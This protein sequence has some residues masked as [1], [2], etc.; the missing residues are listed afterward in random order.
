MAKRVANRADRVIRT[1]LREAVHFQT[2]TE[3][4]TIRLSSVLEYTGRS[5]FAPWHRIL[6]GTHDFTNPAGIFTPLVFV[7]VETA[8][9]ACDPNFRVEV[10][11]E[12]WLGHSRDSS[13]AV[14]NIVREGRHTVV[15]PGGAVLARARLLNVFTRYDPDPAR[16]RVTELP[17]E[18]GLGA[19]PGR[20]I[21]LP[22]IESLIDPARKPDFADAGAHVWHYGQTDPNRHINGTAYL[23][24]MEEFAADSLYAAGHDLRRLYAARARIIYRKPSFRGE[25]YRRVAWFRSEAPLVLAGAFY[26][27]KQPVDAQ[28][29]VAIE[30]TLLQHGEQSRS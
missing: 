20:A 13:G 25:G 4:R 26:N 29:A 6:S 16:R 30:L 12:S 5:H 10:R 1:R 22:A 27:E 23:R 14:R 3:N 21:E 11:G 15:N 17:A 19:L 9:L 8:D 7:E 2:L 24:A 28:P 18:L